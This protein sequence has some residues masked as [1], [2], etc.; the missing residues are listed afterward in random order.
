[1]I[2]ESYVNNIR[3]FKAK[4]PRS[5][6]VGEANLYQQTICEYLPDNPVSLAYEEF[7]KELIING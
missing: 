6:K 3:I 1:M 4:I 5:V 2:E 7:V